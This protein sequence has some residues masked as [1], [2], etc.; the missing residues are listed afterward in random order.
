MVINELGFSFNMGLAPFVGWG[1][2]LTPTYIYLFMPY[3]YSGLRRFH[4]ALVQQIQQRLRPNPVFAIQGN[5]FLE[6]PLA[7]IQQP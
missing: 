4:P 3:G 5:Q 7:F 1:S 6:N 2:F